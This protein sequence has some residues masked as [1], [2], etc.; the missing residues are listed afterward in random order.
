MAVAF[1]YG[2]NQD[3]GVHSRYKSEPA[4]RLA[5]QVG[6]CGNEYMCLCTC[7]AVDMHVPELG[8]NKFR[9]PAVIRRVK[10]SPRP[11]RIGPVSPRCALNT[12]C[13]RAP[14]R[15]H[16]RSQ[17]MHT[18]FPNTSLTNITA[19]G[20]FSGPLV[21]GVTST[22]TGA[23]RVSLSHADGLQFHN[24]TECENQVRAQ[25][26]RDLSVRAKGLLWR[27]E[28]YRPRHLGARLMLAPV[29]A[30]GACSSLS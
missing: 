18:A 4:R 29:A 1:D 5:L 13:T 8:L 19:S 30:V 20:E 9:S 12:T 27:S 26:A 16:W 11:P 22:S 2:D 7:V 24:T 25:H 21:G 10:S 28:V 3:H 17:V 15:A 23:L 6:Q 14:T